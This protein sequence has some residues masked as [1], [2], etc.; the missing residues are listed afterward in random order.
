MKKAIAVGNTGHPQY[1][2][3]NLL[4]II[5]IFQTPKR[6]KE[7]GIHNRNS[8]IVRSFSNFS[9]VANARW[10]NFGTN[11]A[12]VTGSLKD[13]MMRATSLDE[14][15]QLSKSVILYFQK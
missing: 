1:G 4:R 7:S 2:E 12:Y 10:K 6:T 3:S 14:M 11:K 9:C 8:I 15:K 5:R 13:E